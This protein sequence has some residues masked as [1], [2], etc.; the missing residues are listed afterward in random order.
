MPELPFMNE[1]TILTNLSLTSPPFS[2]LESQPID[3]DRWEL[4]ISPAEYLRRFKDT[5]ATVQLTS[6]APRRKLHTTHHRGPGFDKW[7]LL[8]RSNHQLWINPKYKED[9]F[10]ELNVYQTAQPGRFT[11]QASLGNVLILTRSSYTASP[12]PDVTLSA[13]KHTARRFP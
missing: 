3:V 12:K 2:D 13:S 6:W 7:L 10:H 1:F 8:G 4:V 11:L 5:L 9:F